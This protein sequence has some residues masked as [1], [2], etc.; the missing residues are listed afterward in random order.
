M[1]RNVSPDGRSPLLL[2]LWKGEDLRFNPTADGKWHEYV[3]DCTTSTAWAKWTSEGRIGLALPVPTKG[4]IEVELK[5]IQ[6]EN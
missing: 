3:I 2:I 1:N 4:E 6:L 5:T